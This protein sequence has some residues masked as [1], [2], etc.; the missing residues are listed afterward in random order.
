MLEINKNTTEAIKTLLNAKSGILDYLKADIDINNFDYRTFG[1]AIEE[2]VAKALILIFKEN[3]FIQIPE[4]YNVALNKNDFPDF[5]LH[6]LPNLAIEFK[7]GNKSQLRKGKW[8]TVKNSENDM[9]TLN[10]WPKKIAKYGGDFIYYV[11][12]LYNFNDQIQEINEIQ[13]APFYKFIGI[14]NGGVLKYR[15]KDGNLRPKNFDAIPLINSLDQFNSLLNKTL[16]YR[17]K[18]IITKHKKIIKDASLNNY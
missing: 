12:V 7:S 14:N 5:T 13:I 17:S 11:F 10:E 1:T 18:R 4:D 2:H 16:V 9:G 3:H 15:E 8:V 6:T